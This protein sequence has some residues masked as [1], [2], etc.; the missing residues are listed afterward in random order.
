MVLGVV[1]VYP[2]NLKINTYDN[3][4]EVTDTTME[5]RKKDRRSYAKI[6]DFPFLTKQGVVRKDRRQLVE[7]RVRDRREARFKA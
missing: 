1:L 2:S 4:Q 5:H 6:P 7:R 3:E